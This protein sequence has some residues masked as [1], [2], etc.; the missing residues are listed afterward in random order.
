MARDFTRKD[1][2]QLI[3]EHKALELRIREA[4]RELQQYDARLAA[5]VQAAQ[6]SALSS[7]FSRSTLDVINQSLDANTMGKLVKS[8]VTSFQQLLES[9]N[10]PGKPS[11][12]GPQVKA[13]VRRI[14]QVASD[15][16]QIKLDPNA[17]DQ[18]MTPLVIALHQARRAATQLAECESL[19]RF[20]QGIQE[21]SATV[22]GG[23]KFFQWT[24]GSAA[25]KQA[26]NDAYEHLRSTLNGSYS[27]RV[28]ALQLE[29]QNISRAQ[30]FGAWNDF[31]HNAQACFSTLDAIAPN[32]FAGGP[33]AFIMPVCPYNPATAFAL[34]QSYDQTVANL[35]AALA[36]AQDETLHEQ[37]KADAQDMVRAEIAEQLRQIPVEELNRG[38]KGFRVSALRK[39]GFE[40]LDSVANA[41]THQLASVNGISEAGA[42]TIKQECDRFA[43]QLEPGIRLKLSADD[44]TLEATELV[45]SSYVVIAST[46]ATPACELYLSQANGAPAQARNALVR[47]G[48]DQL[49]WLVWD[50]MRTQKQKA[51]DALIANCV[52]VDA[53]NS[54][55][56]QILQNALTPNP[57]RAWEAFARSPFEFYNLLEEIVPEYIGGSGAYGLPEEIAREIE[58]QEF[59]PQGLACTLRRYQEFGVKYALHQQRVLL[60]DEMGLGKTVQA[61]ATMVSL[62]NTG[63]THFMVVCPASVLVNWCRE[64]ADKSDLSV[65]RIHGDGASRAM[66]AWSEQGGVAVTTYETTSRVQKPEEASLGLLIV[67][68]AHYIKNPEARRSKSVRNLC[69][70]AERVL[71]M[72]GTALE[73]KVDEM[74]QLL[75]VLRP[76]VAERASEM[77]SLASAPAFRD[78]IAPVYYR[79]RREDVLAEMPGLME[80]KEWCDLSGSEEREAYENAVLSRNFMQARRVS[81]NVDN[82]QAMSSKAKRL[83]EIVEDAEDDGRKVIV[84]SYFRDT[85]AAIRAILGDK[86]SE[87]INGSVTPAKRQEILDEFNQAPAGSVLVAQIQSGG[88]GLN[89]QAASVVVICEPQ[90]KPSVENQAVARAYRMGQT[91]NVLVY[92]LL[93]EDTIDE[94]ITD[95]LAEKQR[96]FDAFADE[97][98]TAIESLELDK[99]AQ[100]SIIEQEVERITAE[101]GLS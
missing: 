28:Q 53:W 96:A 48:Y 43:S 79:R 83:L 36:A 42:Q 80:T 73:N 22:G 62:R 44:Q 90:L 54:N 87:P 10:K 24:F 65:T 21:A 32:R 11:I 59:D 72:T 92:R 66:Q 71:F 89:I 17:Q 3:Q 85:L 45:T 84:F 63:E 19:L 75:G 95:I 18:S 37:I 7:L 58:A 13:E 39:A 55:G 70:Q 76:A 8:G 15:R 78:A 20:N 51:Y 47:G 77:A 16:L 26:V 67:D 81:W 6:K 61:I 74:V 82:I 91:R 100:A 29:V 46:A 14:E 99:A 50:N 69:R 35:Q 12:L 94:R 34:I 25:Q 2:A 86:A 1:A 101:K 4:Q 60:G 93:C 27:Q 38:G 88:T 40:N 9:L 97:S 57:A 41:S 56:A 68:E 30:A 64:V 49:A 33:R 23:T 52:H 98:S 31:A 5:T